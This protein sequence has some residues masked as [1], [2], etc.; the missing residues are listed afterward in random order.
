MRQTRGSGNGADGADTPGLA[1]VLTRLAEASRQAHTPRPASA[2]AGPK[3]D[4]GRAGYTC[5]ACGLWTGGYGNGYGRCGAAPAKLTGERSPA[6]PDFEC[7]GGEP[8][9]FP[10]ETE[11]ARPASDD[12]R[13]AE[14]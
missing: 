13:G 11:G 10:W 6:C 1:H 14:C 9:D 12:E 8:P 7:C 4:Y 2:P 5:G 3:R